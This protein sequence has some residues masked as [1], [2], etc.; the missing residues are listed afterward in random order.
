MIEAA[1]GHPLHAR[2]R[3]YAAL[4]LNPTFDPILAR[5]A[6][7]TWQAIAARSPTP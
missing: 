7:A 3:L 1:L 6:R 5:E 4:S 2:Q